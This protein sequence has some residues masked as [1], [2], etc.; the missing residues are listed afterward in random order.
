MSGPIDTDQTESTAGE[1]GPHRLAP[2]GHLEPIGWAAAGMTLLLAALWGGNAVAVKYSVGTLEPIAVAGVRFTL[3]TLFMLVWCRVEGTSLRLRREQV[4]PAVFL[5][6][7]LFVQ[8]SLFTVGTDWS[9]SSHSALFISTF[10]F[11]VAGI[12]HFVTR[13]DRLSPRRWI[14]LLIAA[15]G[16]ILIFAVKP[17]A[18]VAAAHASGS[19]DQPHLLGD[20][21][22]V[23]SAG[24][25]GVKLTYTRHALKVIGPGKLIF[26]HDLIGV[27]FFAIASAIFEETSWD[28]FTGEAIIGLLYQGVV[29]G[30]FCFAMYARL[31]RRH[32]ASQLSVFSFATPLFGIA[33]A[34]LFRGDELSPWLG[35]AAICVV[36]G[37]YLVNSRARGSL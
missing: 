18:G 21:V 28:D 1:S 37:I 33:L 20:L 8:I 16:V 26:W 30:G 14:G 36:V 7:L 32:S 12:E 27:G 3:A 31:L 4:R 10:I 35:I 24:V 2:V 6:F 17:D 9:N 5:G 22:L 34:V 23:A 19:T 29:V 15:G 13:T 11:W 25:L